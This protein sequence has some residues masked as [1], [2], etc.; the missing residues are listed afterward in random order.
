MVAGTPNQLR[1]YW[2]YQVSDLANP[3]GRATPIRWRLTRSIRLPR[4]PSPARAGSR[5][6]FYPSVRI[7]SVAFAR[8]DYN[9]PTGSL[10]VTGATWTGEG[11][12]PSPPLH[13]SQR[14]HRLPCRR[15]YHG[16][17][18]G[19]EGERHPGRLQWHV[20]G[21]RRNNHDRAVRTGGRSGY[22]RVRRLGSRA[23]LALVSHHILT[24]AGIL[25]W[26]I[27]EMLRPTSLRPLPDTGTYSHACLVLHEPTRCWPVRMQP[28][29]EWITAHKPSANELDTMPSISQ[30][31]C[32]ASGGG[33]ARLWRS[34]TR[35]IRRWRYWRK[36]AR[37][38]FCS[39]V[40]T[41]HPGTAQY[42]VAGLAPGTYKASAERHRL[43]TLPGNGLVNAGDNSLSFASTAGNI[44]ITALFYALT[45]S[46][47]AITFTCTA[48][49][50]DAS[51]AAN[52]A[53]CHG[54]YPV[55]LESCKNPAVAF[56]FSVW[57]VRTGDDGGFGTLRGAGSGALQR[58]GHRIQHAAGAVAV[59]ENASGL[60]LNVY[61]APENRA[62]LLPFGV[63]REIYSTFLPVSGGHG[64]F[65]SSARERQ[66]LR[67]HTL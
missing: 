67:R 62:S 44:S 47:S 59:S 22:A 32:S 50:F 51:S 60:T 43:P 19:G 45:L 28:T 54:D 49:E 20:H 53:G 15:D 12:Q 14:S 9:P 13:I 6:K 66:P 18:R 46:E 11:R 52:R 37:S 7:T 39:A 5:P 23:W 25:G 1:A 34:A 17:R 30:P 55:R 57:R 56:R 58:Y 40:T 48:V 26:D 33:C 16:D 8:D 4:L 35:R 31:A 38:W 64:P 10:T 61:G 27:T 24:R 21:Y 2:H 42:V 65:T 63:A 36:E 3:P 41:S 29:G